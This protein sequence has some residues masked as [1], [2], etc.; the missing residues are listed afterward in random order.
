MRMCFLGWSFVEYET[1]DIFQMY[2]F[3]KIEKY[4]YHFK[5]FIHGFYAFRNSIKMWVTRELFFKETST[6]KHGLVLFSGYFLFDLQFLK[7]SRLFQVRRN[8][9]D[10]DCAYRF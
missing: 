3:D 6:N 8:E 5:S 7:F 2:N 10:V 1:F 9:L 4:W